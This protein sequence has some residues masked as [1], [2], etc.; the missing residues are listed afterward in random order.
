MKLHVFLGFLCL[1]LV[2]ACGDDSSGSVTDSGTDD[3]SV[4]GT[5][6][7]YLAS[8]IR[9][10]EVMQSGDNSIAPGFNLDGFT[11]NPCNDAIVDHVSPPPDNE[12]GV[13]NQLIT[14]AKEISDLNSELDLDALLQSGTLAGT[15]GILVEVVA[16]DLT[17]GPATVK[18][19]LGQFDGEVQTSGDALSP[20]QKLTVT[21]TITSANGTI[22]NGRLEVGADSLPLSFPAE[23]AKS[24]MINL[25]IEPVKA[26]FTISETALTNG[27]IGGGLN[28]Q[29]VI[30]EVMEFEAILTEAGFDRA[31]IESAVEPKSDIEPAADG[32][33]CEAISAGLYIEGVTADF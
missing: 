18:F 17:N 7:K 28:T 30:D 3:S 4:T 25:T 21:Q 12:P 23:T 33:S 5:S 32:Q 11:D 10:G 27:F 14:I 19:H 26:R 8:Q 16:E 6:Y 13:D 29:A 31:T 15:V 2:S 20:G 22:T 24:G 9:I 1:A